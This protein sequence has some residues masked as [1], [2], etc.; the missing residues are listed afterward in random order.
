MK[1]L[2]SNRYRR[3]LE[4]I[5]ILLQKKDWVHLK[6]LA[7]TLDCTTRI[8]KEDLSQLRVA[9]E[10]IDFQSSTRGVRI[11]QPDSLNIER[12]YHYF[13]EESVNFSLLE[14]L[15]FH[16]HISADELAQRF[17]ISLSTLYHVVHKISKT[18]QEKYNITIRLNPVRLVGDE[19]DIRYFYAQY[20]AERYFF[21]DWPFEEFPKKVVQELVF[22]FYQP[23]H[24][25]MNFATLQMV[26]MILA[27]NLYRIKAGYFS[28][29]PTKTATEFYPYYRLLPDFDEKNAYFTQKLGIPLTAENIEQ[30]FISFTQTHFFISIESFRISRQQNHYTKKSYELLVEI[31]QKVSHQYKL[32]IDNAEELIWYLHNTAH[33]ERQ[34]IFSDY[35]LFN[36]KKRTV[37]LY[38]HYFPD[39]FGTLRQELHQYR[40][41]LQRPDHG[42]NL[43]QLVYTFFTH[44]NKIL[45]QLLTNTP[46][47]KV[48]V[49]SNFDNAHSMTLIDILS[50]YSA[51]HFSFNSWEDLDISA[52]KLNESH[53]DIVIA[54]FLIP[55]IE[56]PFICTTNLTIWEIISQ[57]KF[58]GNQFLLGSP[59][60]E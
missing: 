22:Y 52:Q 28:H 59:V 32:K 40:R 42:D 38:Q 57:L 8:L 13:F 16:H 7:D 49:I 34:E 5:E 30:M 53:Y 46:P 55:G 3:Q 60:E 56:K 36:K 50:Y 23:M 11:A 18:L 10:D 33:L 26:N 44:G 25:P 58:L 39:F 9:F 51:N 47:I 31:I 4:L 20:F 12:V 2:L 35:L 1:K 21:L 54:N 41:E 29:I 24:F 27:V 37:D 15:F 48:L 43:E 19:M 6:D 14:Y 17:D 45:A